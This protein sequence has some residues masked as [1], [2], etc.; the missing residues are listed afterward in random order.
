MCMLENKYL[1]KLLTAKG[2]KLIVGEKHVKW[3]FTIIMVIKLKVAADD[4]TFIL[5]G[6]DKV[7][8]FYRLTKHGKCQGKCRPKQALRD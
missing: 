1:S 2:Q 4:E 6:C 7:R 8:L 3:R 5:R